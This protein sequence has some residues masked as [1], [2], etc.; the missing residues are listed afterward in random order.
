MQPDQHDILKK[1]IESKKE[2]IRAY[3]FGFI[4]H[5]GQ[6]QLMTVGNLLDQSFICKSVDSYINEVL[7]GRVDPNN[8]LNNK[9]VALKMGLKKDG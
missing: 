8:A 3:I 9:E 5:D 4:N 1:V 6:T 7:S 2:S